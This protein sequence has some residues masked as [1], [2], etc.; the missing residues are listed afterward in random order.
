MDAQRAL[1]PAVT[2]VG[3]GRAGTALAAALLAAGVAVRG[4]LGRGADID[5]DP[6]VLLCVP[7]A[8][9]AAV[10]AALPERPG[11]LVGHVSG[12][13]SLAPL[14]PHEAFSVHPL[15]TIPR[16][17]ADLAGTT[18]AVAGS[19]ERALA[20]ATALATACG[21]EPVAV[22]DEDRV[23]YHAAACLASN[24]LVVLEDAAE[25]LAAT[26]GLP[27]ER[28]VP[29]VRATVESW[30][31]RGGADA[32]TGPIAR[33]DE[34]T[35]GRHRAV[36]AERLPEQLALFDALAGATRRLAGRAA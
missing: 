11:R 29:L 16:D 10:A 14:A 12:A 30:A 22:A 8:A 2:V 27:R 34:E 36:L 35:V 31:L 1:P 26:A 17:G 13:T 6:V 20:V 18:A 4:P 25:Q 3:A 5:D 24:F 9:I 7:D 32:L 15:M 19:S 23:A 28:L 21:M 33:G